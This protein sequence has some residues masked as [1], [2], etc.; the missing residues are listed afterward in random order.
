MSFGPIGIIIRKVTGDSS[1]DGNSNNEHTKSKEIEALKLF[2][3]GKTPL[4]VSITLGISSDETE[5]LYFGCLRL[6]HLH[7]LVLIHKE[8][9]YQLLSFIKLYRILRRAGIRTEDAANLIKAMQQI[10]FRRNTFLD[11]T[12][13]NA[14]LKEQRKETISELTSIKTEVET[15][16][17]YL[18][19]YVE[20]LKRVIFEIGE[21]KRELHYV[22]R[23]TNVNMNGY[24]SYR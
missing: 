5:N 22:N 3:Q 14:N 23:L 19:C 20:E 18:Q 8:L 15:K 11:L 12:N 16:W 2:Q 4:D 21:R 13:A 7:R 17:S 24:K 9:K 1:K 10:P 6:V